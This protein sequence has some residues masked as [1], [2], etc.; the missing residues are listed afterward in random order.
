MVWWALVGTEVRQHGH[1]PNDG[2]NLCRSRRY[3]PTRRFPPGSY[4]ASSL[5]C[6][7]S[8]IGCTRAQSEEPIPGR[9]KLAGALHCLAS[10]ADGP[11]TTKLAC[12][13]RHQDIVV[14]QGNLEEH[15]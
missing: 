9:L 3:L 1:S 2:A 11:A 13:L 8:D 4:N 7:R 15:L 12:T 5:V 14:E 6:I 10:R